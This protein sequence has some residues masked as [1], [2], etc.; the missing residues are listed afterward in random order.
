MREFIDKT[1]V[2]NGTPINRENLMAI[3][4]FEAETISFNTDGSITKTN[5]KG[6]TLR[7]VFKNDG[8][9]TKTF[10]GKKSITMTVTF[11]SDGKIVK[12]LS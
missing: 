11:G 4:G 9:I 7:I 3:Q 1:S 10:T 2:Q 5:G 6:E 12:S 8:S